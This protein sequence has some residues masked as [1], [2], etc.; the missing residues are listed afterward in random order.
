MFKGLIAGKKNQSATDQS[1]STPYFK[2]IYE[3]YSKDLK[4][5]PIFNDIKSEDS[6]EV[7]KKGKE[8]L[9]QKPKVEKKMKETK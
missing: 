1:N 7:N 9:D 3:S 8:E 6:Q 5:I 2:T 4:S